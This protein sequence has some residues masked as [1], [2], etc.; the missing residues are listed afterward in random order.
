MKMGTKCDSSDDEIARQFWATA[1]ATFLKGYT[2]VK[3][4]DTSEVAVKEQ[5][6][7]LEKISE[8]HHCENLK[9]Y[10]ESYDCKPEKITINC[11]PGEW[12]IQLSDSQRCRKCTRAY[13]P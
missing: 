6:K 2:S 3:D 1:E 8:S 11:D 4:H 13:L 12:I 10:L 9:S 5:H 7:T